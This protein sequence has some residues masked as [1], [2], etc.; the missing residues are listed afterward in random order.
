MS[1]MVA[2][3]CL[4]RPYTTQQQQIQQPLRQ[5]T[6]QALHKTAAADTTAT[7]ATHPAGPTQHSSI[8][9]SHYGNTPSRPYT[10]QQ[11]IQQP[12]RQHTQQALHNTAAYTAA[13]TA[14]HPAGPTQHSSIYSSHYGNTPS[15]PYTTQ[16]HIQQSLWQHTQQALINTAA[17]RAVT[18]A[19][20]PAGPTQHSSIYSSHYGNTPSRP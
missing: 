2:C 19:T 6:Q 3:S 1:S 11:H 9:S 13:T 16:Q 4:R 8:C 17:Y 10:T 7:T 14:T 5:H 15:R 20:H 12:L 18:T